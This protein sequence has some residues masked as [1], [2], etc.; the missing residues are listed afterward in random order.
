MYYSKQAPSSVR[1]PQNYSGNAFRP[2]DEDGTYYENNDRFAPSANPHPSTADRN[3]IHGE[4]SA[5]RNTAQKNDTADQ[6]HPS[7]T[8]S[9]SEDSTAATAASQEGAS[10]SLFAGIGTEELLLL[11][12]ILLLHH[13]SDDNVAL[14]MLLFILLAG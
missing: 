11:G 10:T 13:E 2:I 1:V 12:L 14:L 8:R 5:A 6:R 3:M 7:A 9:P 4:R